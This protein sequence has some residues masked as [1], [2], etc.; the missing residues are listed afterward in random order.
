[1]NTKKSLINKK[2]T[3]SN[4]S[5]VDIQLEK[6]KHK[7]S[8]ASLII[9]SQKKTIYKLLQIFSGSLGYI[10]GL[11][12]LKNIVESLI[13]YDL[14]TK[15]VIETQEKI[16]KSLS[17]VSSITSYYFLFKPYLTGKGDAGV[18]ELSTYGIFMALSTILYTLSL[19]SWGILKETVQK[20]KDSLYS[21]LK[22][23]DNSKRK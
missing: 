20:K 14:I 2:P 4:R 1:M 15:R 5:Q 8:K 6:N 22:K 23:K 19:A 13:G 18:E 10:W 9:Q 3:N 7:L 12:P 11:W 17:W 21:V 16:L